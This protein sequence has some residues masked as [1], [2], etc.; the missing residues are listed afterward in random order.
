MSRFGTV[1]QA[2]RR[3]G[4][5]IGVSALR[6]TRAQIEELEGAVAETRRLDVLL[7]AEVRALEERVADV[8]AAF[9]ARR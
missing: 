6:R 2:A 7:A 4:R 9:L 3:L 1:G 5:G 8:A